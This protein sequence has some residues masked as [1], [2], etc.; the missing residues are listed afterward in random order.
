MNN[1]IKYL[2]A[3][4]SIIILHVNIINSNQKTEIGR[5]DDKSLTQLCNLQ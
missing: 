4:M 3:N 1:K 2:R 5:V